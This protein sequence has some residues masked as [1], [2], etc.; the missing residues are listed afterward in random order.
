MHN[1]LFHLRKYGEGK[2][3]AFSNKSAGVKQLENI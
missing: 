2:E 3:G 1:S